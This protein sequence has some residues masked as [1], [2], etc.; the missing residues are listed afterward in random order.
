M[1]FQEQDKVGHVEAPREGYS[2]SAGF[3][4]IMAEKCSADFERVQ[5]A[6]RLSQEERRCICLFLVSQGS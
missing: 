4:L 5:L 2:P 3:T 1:L 6:E